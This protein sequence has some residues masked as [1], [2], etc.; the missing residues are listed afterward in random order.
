MA[1]LPQRPASESL[2]STENRFE[3]IDIDSQQGE[4]AVKRVNFRLLQFYCT[5]NGV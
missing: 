3:N 2:F 4:G 5:K 1:Y